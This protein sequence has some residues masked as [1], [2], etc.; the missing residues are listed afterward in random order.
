MQHL[1]AALCSLGLARRRE[2][3]DEHDA[4]E[5]LLHDGVGRGGAR[6]DADACGAV[7]RQEVVG[8]QHLAIDGA[9]LDRV[10]GP[11]APGQGEGLGVARGDTC[12]I[13]VRYM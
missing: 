9:V 6:G 2:L 5:A 13:H 3:F 4:L 8:D 10:V 7:E 11:D 1:H 12:E